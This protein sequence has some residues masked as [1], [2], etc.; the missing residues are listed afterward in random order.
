MLDAPCTGEGVIA[1]DPSRKTSRKPKDLALMHKVQV[2]L[3]DR[4]LDSL[5]RGGELVYSTC[6]IAPEENEMV[7]DAI[8]K[9]REDVEVVDGG[10]AGSPGITKYFG[11]EFPFANKCRRLWPHVHGSEGFFVCK[12]KKV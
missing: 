10:E 8:L 12:L 3:L 11:F 1:R 7:I 5:K 6:S 2:V 4:A 9:S